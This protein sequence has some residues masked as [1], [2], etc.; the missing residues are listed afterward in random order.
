VCPAGM[1]KVGIL[2]RPKC[3]PA[4]GVG[5]LIGVSGRSFMVGVRSLALQAWK[6][7]TLPWPDMTAPSS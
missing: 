2:Q 5:D 4:G 3:E 7:A 1:V 6:S